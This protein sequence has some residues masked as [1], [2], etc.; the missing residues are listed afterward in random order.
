VAAVSIEP[1]DLTPF[2]VIDETKAQAM[3][4]DA[5]ALAARVAPCILEDDFE[6]AAAAKAILRGAILR[7][8]DAGS[9][10][11][12][13]QTAGPFG[14]TLDTRQVRKGMFWPTEIEQLQELCDLSSTVYTTSLAGPDPAEGEVWYP[15]YIPGWG[16]W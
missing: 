13:A 14:Q 12:S 11:L 16:P 6:Y 2:A 1:S 8:N 10:A 7:W 9:G 4:D 3:I 5:L 15:P